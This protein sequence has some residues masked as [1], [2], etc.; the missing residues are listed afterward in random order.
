MRDQQHDFSEIHLTLTAGDGHLLAAT[1]FEPRGTPFAAVQINGATGVRRRYYRAYAQFLAAQGYAVLCYDYR[2]IGDSQWRGIAPQQLRMRHWGERDLAAMLAWLK[3]RYPQAPLYT[4]GHSAGGQLLGLA[5]NN[6]LVDAA[7]AIAAQ[8]GYWRLWPA[9]LQPTMAALWYG[10]LPAAV[11]LRGKVPAAL[12]G[13]E[14]PG[15]VAREWARWC[16]SPHYISDARGRPLREHFDAYR[17]RMRFYAIADDAFYAPLA[18]VRELA[19]FY[20]HARSDVRV[21]DG[22][23]HGLHRLGHFGFFRSEARVLW[24]LTL[25]W[26]RDAAS[27]S[28]PLAA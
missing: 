18:A 2:G 10:V 13:S 14:L 20:R 6:H 19:G 3:Q 4:I 7:L 12:M 27:P 22:R 8:S 15:G 23:A 9:H 1:L 24:P 26:L 28:L 21:L 17:G 11:A 5:A 16:R 25:A